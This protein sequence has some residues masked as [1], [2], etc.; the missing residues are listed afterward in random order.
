M[1]KSK[2]NTVDP[3]E[4][5]KVFGADSV[6]W[7]ILSDSPPEKDVQWSAN[8]V[9]SANKFLQKIWDLNSTIIKRKQKETIKDKE[10]EFESKINSFLIK[11][12]GSINDFK[13][14]VTIA[15]FYEVFKFIKNHAKT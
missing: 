7:F 12:D 3:E 13:F 1:S 9:S 10:I 6:R 5:I 4:M 2:K 8:G 11:I 15:H 14:N